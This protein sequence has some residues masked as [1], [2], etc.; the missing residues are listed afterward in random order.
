MP[1]RDDFTFSQSSLQDAADCQR[2][3]ELRYIAQR[4]YPAPETDDQLAFEDWMQRG[5]GFH[6]LVQQHL[7]GIPADALN[8]T[9]ND[10]DLR[11]WWERYLQEGLRDLP[12]TVRKPEMTLVAPVN[13]YRLLAK[14]DL[15]AIEPGQRAVIIDWKTSHKTPR[16]ESL[17]ARWQTRVYRYV[18][19]AA[20]AHLFGADIPPE[21]VEMRYWYAETGDTIR[22]PYS[23]DA[24]KDDERDL[25]GMIRDLAERQ[26]FPLTDNERHCR[27]CAYR[28][29]CERGHEP[30]SLD[31][32]LSDEAPDFDAEAAIIDP[33]QIAEIEF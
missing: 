6:R 14:Y 4:Q 22:F 16:R 8:A 17:A 20:G 28:T 11:R 13:G 15:L 24:Y 18:L 10:D 5:A 1:L 32:Y 26:I 27:F 7:V 33:D 30:G 21:A 23:H 29:L 2:R 3:F 19:V 31:D 12:Q 25:R 9:I